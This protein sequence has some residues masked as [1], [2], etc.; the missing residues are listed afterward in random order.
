[1][2]MRSLQPKYAKHLM[3]F[4]QTDIG[5]LIEELYGIEESISRGLWYDSSILTLRGRD[6]LEGRDMEMLVL[7]VLFG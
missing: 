1:M 7:S 4:S 5:A 2:L 3:V 6:H